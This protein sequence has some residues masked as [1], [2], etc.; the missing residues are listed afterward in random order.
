MVSGLLNSQLIIVGG[1]PP[2]S[3]A[4]GRELLLYAWGAFVYALG[5]LS[6]SWLSD[7]FGRVKCIGAV[8]IFLA[9]LNGLLGWNIFNPYSIRLLFIY[10]GLFNLA[11]PVFYTAVE[12]LLSEYQDHKIPLARR[13][14]IYCLSWCAGDALGA[15]L[16][17][18]T[19]QWAG[20]QTVY[21]GLFM[22]CMAAFIA[23][24]FDWMRHGSRK[25]GTQAHEHGDIRPDT[26]FYARLGRI[27][28]FFSCIVW[29]ALAASFPRFGRDFH[30]LSDG[31]IG[32]L[33]STIFFTNMVMFLWFPLWKRWQYNAVLQICLQ[34]ATPVGLVLAFFTPS[35]SVLL[36]R[37]AFILV[38]FGWSVSYFFS[39]Y[40][41]LSVASDHA[42]SGGLHEGF[43]SLGSL[44][45]SL[46]AIGMMTL[47]SRLNLISVGRLGA[48]AFLIGILGMILSLL[49]QSAFLKYRKEG[50]SG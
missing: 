31:R 28:L 7:R 26:V 20:P 21:R 22:L 5:S 10:W 42:H 6:L 2:G 34:C 46:A 15:F 18:Y 43:L 45:G 24:F 13:L 12:G 35:G 1:T 27:G 29:G 19:K 23:V 36:L 8:S 4:I 17:G 41:S 40:Y 3:V 38:G 25:L 32:N 11:L 48:V 33:L 37:I 50:F 44:A 49:L 47:S 14:G 39:I 30:Y 9:L 16:T